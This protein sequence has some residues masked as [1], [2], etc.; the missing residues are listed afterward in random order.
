MTWYSLMEVYHDYVIDLL[1]VGTT[2]RSPLTV[3][4]HPVTGPFVQ[5][6]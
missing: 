4:E 3:S 1:S 2:L 6:T 5:G